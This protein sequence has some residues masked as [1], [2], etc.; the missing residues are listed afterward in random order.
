MKPSL[1][2]L[3][4]ALLELRTLHEE[5]AQMSFPAMTDCHSEQAKLCGTRPARPRKHPERPQS[6]APVTL[7]GALS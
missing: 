1:A 6:K 7:S 2:K 5:E 4:M 3:S